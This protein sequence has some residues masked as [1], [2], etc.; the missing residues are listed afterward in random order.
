MRG[1]WALKLLL[2]SLLLPHSRGWGTEGEMAKKIELIRGD[3]VATG[4]SERCQQFN[5]CI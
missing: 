4:P 2:L 3:T 5:Q 1:G